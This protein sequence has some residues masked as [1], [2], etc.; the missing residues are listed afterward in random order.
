M[1]HT[2][3]RQIVEDLEYSFVKLNELG[4]A[5]V[6]AHGGSLNF[7]KNFFLVPQRGEWSILKVP[8]SL[9]RHFAFT[10]KQKGVRLIFIIN[11]LV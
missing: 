4:K 5:R 2:R 1:I 11:S 7:V 8:F 6:R 9:F 10:F 3:G